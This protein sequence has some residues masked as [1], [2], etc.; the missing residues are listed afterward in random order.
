MGVIASL[1]LL[2]TAK[3]SIQQ[4]VSV[5]FGVYVL[6]IV[7]Y[8]ILSLVPPGSLGPLERAR[9]F[10]DDVCGPYLRLLRRFIPPLGP[11]DLSPMAGIFILVFGGRLVQAV[12]ERI[13]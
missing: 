13:L 2:G 1:I 7:A 8:V 9:G 12:L 4:F 10:L 11:L 3:T 5:F 6:L